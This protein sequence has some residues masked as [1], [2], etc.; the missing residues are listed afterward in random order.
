MSF[1]TNH[2][3][4]K[5]KNTF[6]RCK[7]EAEKVRAQ[8]L[9][10]KLGFKWMSEDRE[11]RTYGG[12]AKG[13]LC[14]DGN[15]RITYT[16]GH[17][18][19]A[20]AGNE[21]TMYDLRQAVEAYAVIRKA[22]KKD[23]RRRASVARM[24]AQGWIKN[25]GVRP[26]G[27]IAVVLFR[28]G[29]IRKRGQ[30]GMQVGSYAIPYEG[31][32]GKTVEYYKLEQPVTV[33]LEEMVTDIVKASGGREVGKDGFIVWTGEGF[34]TRDVSYAPGSMHGP[35]KEGTRVDVKLRGGDVHLNQRAGSGTFASGWYWVNDGIDNDIV[36]YRVCSET[37]LPATTATDIAEIVENQTP[38]YTGG[39]VSYYK[40]EVENPTSGG[41]P[42]T[43]ECNDIIEALGMNYAEG[44]AFKA[45]WRMCAARNGKAKANY[46]DGL[47]DAEK[48]VF[49]GQ[50]MVAQNTVK[51]E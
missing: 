25:T 43:A 17:S 8:E 42:Y 12:E 7:N 41:E 29:E 2:I 6:I 50:R 34:T 23:Q 18:S 14:I 19:F 4:D 35:V 38:E 37:V 31:G 5:F 16:W 39:S 48:V 1:K 49:F 40:V 9:M 27:K 24:E 20:P 21:T 22:K 46:K 10:F 44:N 47:Y 3:T 33:T 11:V 28:D 30:W 26:E 51:G 32:E 45:I 13:V 36:A 15:N